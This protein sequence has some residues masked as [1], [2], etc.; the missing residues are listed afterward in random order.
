E[1]C[2]AHVRTIGIGKGKDRAVATPR[3]RLPQPEIRVEVAE[4]TE[5]GDA[6]AQCHGARLSGVPPFAES[7]ARA[8]H[9]GQRYLAH[10][11]PIANR[12]VTFPES[13]LRRD[14]SVEECR[15]PGAE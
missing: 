9:E 11:P 6:D 8:P 4:G 12:P 3:E 5:R 7:L 14:P 1:P 10:P 15:L 13:K 2:G